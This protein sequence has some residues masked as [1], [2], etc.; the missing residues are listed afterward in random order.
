MD[1]AWIVNG[2]YMDCRWI[3]NGLSI[4][5]FS[6]KDFFLTYLAIEK[7]PSQVMGLA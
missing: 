5:S 4:D 2:F 6:C 1:S 3:V 7:N